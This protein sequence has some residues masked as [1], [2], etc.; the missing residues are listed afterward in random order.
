MV[1]RPG[2]LERLN[3]YL[4]RQDG[5]QER[6]GFA[7]GLTLISAPAGYGK[8][9]LISEWALSLG[10]WD[11]P[12]TVSWLSLEEDDNDPARFLRYVIAALSK[13][14]GIGAATGGGALS[15]LRSPQPPPLESVLTLLIN[16]IAHHPRRLV[17]FLDD[18]HLIGAQ[19]I[20]DALKFLLEHQP[21]QM[22]LVIATRD[23]PRLPL[24]RFRARGQLA[25]L[26][27]ADLR[28]TLSETSEFLRRVTRLDLSA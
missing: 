12:A 27:G 1:A 2:L 11:P 7:Q 20:H 26:R 25:E 14:E 4:A 21:P 16:E 8:T 13:V 28:F 3:A 17:L 9:T 22:H 24:A 19:P 10:R 5:S 6:P 15:M 23:D 18:Y